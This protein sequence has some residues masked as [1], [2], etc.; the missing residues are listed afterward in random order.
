MNS[1]LYNQQRLD[2]ATPVRISTLRALFTVLAV[3]GVMEGCA[4]QEKLAASDP[5]HGTVALSVTNDTTP[6]ATEVKRYDAALARL[7]IDCDGHEDVAQLEYFSN[8]AVLSVSLSRVEERQSLQIPMV[9]DP[10][11][12]EACGGSP[13]LTSEATDYDVSR[14]FGSNP[15]GFIVS[16][17]CKG[18]TVLG[19]ECNPVHV[20]WNHDS[21]TIDW[22][23]L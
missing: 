20:F 10:E 6:H 15:P 5:A 18:L 8:R 16:Q 21:S 22:W 12:L 14:K 9:N 3:Y 23:R 17:S 11:W 13:L 2:S 1:Q 4:R 19:D 7:D